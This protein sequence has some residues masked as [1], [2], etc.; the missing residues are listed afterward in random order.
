MSE[1]KPFQP[2]LVKVILTSGEVVELPRLTIGKILAVTDAMSTLIT[3]AKDKSPEV[4]KM[5]SGEGGENFGVK[6]VETLPQLFPVVLDQVVN[7][8]SIY[9]GREAK[10]IKET[11]DMEDLVAI[12]TPFFADISK[13]GD[14]KSVV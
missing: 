13:Q 14:R 4:F 1:D 11:M 2:E 12:A 7:V 10:W 8:L 9:L 3:T 5:F 6:L